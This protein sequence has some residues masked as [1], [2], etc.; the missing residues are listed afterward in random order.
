[1]LLLYRVEPESCYKIYIWGYWYYSP[2]S[3]RCTTLNLNL[4]SN[5]QKEVQVQPPGLKL[6]QES[7]NIYLQHTTTIQLSYQKSTG[8]LHRQNFPPIHR[9]APRWQPQ[10]ATVGPRSSALGWHLPPPNEGPFRIWILNGY[11]REGGKLREIHRSPGVDPKEI[12]ITDG[13]V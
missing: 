7:V 8:I 12:E 9:Q 5:L 3:C 10:L 13:R 6:S 2:S 11:L 1:M 4:N